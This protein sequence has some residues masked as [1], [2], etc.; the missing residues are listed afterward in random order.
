MD[1]TPQLLNDVEFREA[2]RGGYNTQDVDEFL[3]RLAVG[4]ERQD[5]AL[6]EALQRAGSAEAR[7][8]DA[9]RRAAE[10]NDRATATSDMDETL[11]RT[12]V[13]A[14]RTADAAIK[15][16]EEH[17][18][19]TLAAATDQASRMLFDAQEATARARADADAEARRA[20]ETAQSLVVA[21]LRELELARDQLHGDV[22]MLQRHLSEQRDRLRLTTRELQRLLD[23]PAS[24][25]EVDL[26]VLSQSSPSTPTFDPA[27]A[28]IRLAP[29]EAVAPPEAVTGPTP[30]PAYADSPDPIDVTDLP[31]QATDVLGDD[32]AY[33]AE[34]RKAMTDESP[35]GPRE[36]DEIGGLFDQAPETD[37]PRFGRKR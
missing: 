13:L 26:P 6:H 18:A 4:L 23:D 11:K 31:T 21:E 37:R 7:I 16:A 1:V 32:D 28:P 8:V 19:Q 10:A 29:V 3:E 2:K 14:Q 20:Q 30:S 24:L 34:L 9:E 22:D 33:L 15:E 35:L 5:S 17:A 12:L 36:D 25:R 27:P